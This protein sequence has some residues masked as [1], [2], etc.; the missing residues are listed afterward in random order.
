MVAA[1]RLPYI[2]FKTIR[3]IGV[4]DELSSAIMTEAAWFERFN[5]GKEVFE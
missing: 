1:K 2:S 3:A 5:E 4:S